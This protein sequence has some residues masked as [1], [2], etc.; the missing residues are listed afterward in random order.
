MTTKNTFKHSS[1]ETSLTSTRPGERLEFSLQHD[2]HL[3]ERDA[4]VIAAFATQE[5]PNQ[6][7]SEWLE[8]SFE[9]ARLL[10]N[11]LNKPEVVAHLERAACDQE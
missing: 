4:L 9:D 2:Q 3:F 5:N 8:L 10:R 11:F 6:E 7:P 1:I